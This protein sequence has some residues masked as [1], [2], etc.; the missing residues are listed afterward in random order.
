MGIAI[1]NSLKVTRLSF[2]IIMSFDNSC[3]LAIRNISYD[4]T[5]E[6]LKELYE[7]FGT[8]EDCKIMRAKDTNKS[9]GFGF[10][11]F[12]KASMVEDAMNSR[13]H[14]LD[15]RTLE[16]HRAAPKEYAKKPESHHT[17]NEIFIGDMKEEITE[18]DLK[19]YFG[20]YGTIE[21][22][23]IPKDKKDETKLRGFAIVAFDDYDPVDVCCYK[24]V[25]Y[26]KDKRL[27]VTKSINRKDM[28]EL[29]R[30]YGND[31]Y[32]NYQSNGNGALLDTLLALTGLQSNFSGPQRNRRGGRGG[33][34]PYGRGK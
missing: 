1:L 20:E 4:S 28:N 25:H 13:P 19:D 10:V 29:K 31:N 6:D 11:R 14:E 3:R 21:R 32:G 18:E 17:C 12:V 23:A 7:K 2:S 15:G 16:P 5:D 34:K 8:V 26:I 33:R 27:Y 30:K 24:N 22:V 9:R